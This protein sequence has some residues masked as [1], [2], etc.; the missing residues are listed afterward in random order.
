MAD[1]AVSGGARTRRT[2]DW[3]LKGAAGL[4]F[5]AALAGQWLFF[6]YIAL[7]YGPS[8]LSGHFEGWTRNHALAK[9]YVPG[10][11]AGNVAFGVHALLAGYVALG[12]GLQLVP[13]IRARFPSFHRWNGR[14]FLTMA[15]GLSLT[16]LYMVWVRDATPTLFGSV[17]TSLNAVLIVVFGA[18]AWRLAMARDFD[19]HRR[20]ALRTFLVANGQWFFRVGTFGWIILNRG[21]V[22]MGE[23]F[24]GPFVVIWSFGCYLF[25]LA[26]F[27][28]YQR[29]RMSP[30]GRG[31][32]A[33]AAALTVLALLTLVGISG[34]YMFMWK[35]V[36]ARL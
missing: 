7:F 2:T 17:A 18:I 29:A 26:I 35:P 34:V 8:T 11:T 19:S 13:Q 30:A 31:R 28:L 10:D 14:V 12:G 25:P 9:G 33:M 1:I 5:L 15:F 20:W 22:G 21:P 23:N 3:A 32:L 27:E 24:D 36:L 16:G 6:Y 4:W